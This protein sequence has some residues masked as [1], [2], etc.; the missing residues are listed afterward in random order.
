MEKEM[1]LIKLIEELINE[2]AGPTTYNLL[3][4]N[5]KN[6]VLQWRQQ[7]FSFFNQPSINSQIKRKI[8]QFVEFHLVDQRE[9]KWN[10]IN[11]YYNSTL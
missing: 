8:F 10:E 6:G 11:W 5:L 7:L 1:R 4:R 9:N 2:A 3:C